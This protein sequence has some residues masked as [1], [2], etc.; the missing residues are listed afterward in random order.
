MPD[1]SGEAAA[2]G[3]RLH[4]SG[5]LFLK[6]KLKEKD[7]PVDYWKVKNYMVA[8]KKAKAQSEVTWCVNKSWEMCPETDEDVW[9]KAVIDAHYYKSQLVNITD[10]KTGKIY[11]E[12]HAEQLQL[13][14]VLGLIRY[15]RAKLASVEGLYIDQGRKDVEAKYPR[16][17]LPMLIQY[18]DNKAKKVLGDTAFMPTPSEEKCK[19]C[20][21]NKKRRGGPCDAGV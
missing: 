5:E 6:G 11:A 8:L 14:A 12:A 2:R 21:F 16:K 20:A 10:L 9:F 17:M 3:T 19:W 15:P 7:L 18:W 1:P 4:L 13:Y